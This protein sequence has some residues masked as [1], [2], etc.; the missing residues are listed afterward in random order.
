MGS[1]TKEDNIL[2]RFALGDTF[3]R[4]AKRLKDKT[5][6][7]FP[8]PGGEVIQYTWDEFDRA[9][10][11]IANGF[12][13]L[14]I[15]KGDKVSI[16]SLNCPQ[17]LFLIYGLAKIGA[18]VTPVN[19]TFTNE[20]VKF[21]VTN[22]EAKM[23][24]VEDTL[25]GRIEN[26]LSEL[27]GVRY[28]YIGVTGATEKPDG[29]VD[30]A[31][32]LDNYSDE[33]PEVQIFVDDIATVTY[34][35]GTEALPKGVILTHGNYYAAASALQSR[36][37][38]DV[39][40]DDIGLQALPLFYTGGIAVATFSLMLGGTLVLLYMPDANT[41]AD[42]ISTYKTTYTVLPPTLYNRLLQV[43]EIE[44]IAKPLRKCVS[45]GAT[46]PEQM[47]TDWIS[48]A[49]HIEWVSLYASSE[50]SALGTAGSFKV[51]DEIPEGDMNWI[52]KP[53]PALE[54]RIVDMDNNEV[55]T[56][57]KG[58]MIFRGPGVMK[59][60][61]KNE[62]KNK[63]IFANGWFHSGDVGRM[64]KDGEVFFVDRIKDM[65]KSGGENIPSAGIE[66]IVSTYP[67]VAECAAFGV[68][69]PDWMEALT[70][71]IIPKE[72]ETIEEAEIIEF[73]KAKLPRFKVPKYV[74]VVDD[75]PRN[76]TGKILKKELRKIYKDI[77][78]KKK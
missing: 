22:S 3:K 47:I 44:D 15:G 37:Y 34:T 64:N 60:Y 26:V 70:V 20:D 49:P 6:L 54:V 13:S 66:F 11:R 21:V 53:A 30:F 51:I 41:I 61:Y 73:C 23:L 28:G 71:A 77:A 29:W 63:E 14:G 1:D 4:N 74:L 43:P 68:P 16:Y 59:G 40:E 76:P 72:G 50:L 67:K 9:I 52:G 19:V 32:M 39:R 38:L 24:F 7:I 46:I 75:F 36:N 27:Q 35:S 18:S 2:R 25:I 48:V 45:F 8:A 65:V 69:H 57:E 33:E 58:E 5:A 10:N 78:S 31:E 17:F 62:E 56:G 55:P 12:L 42:L